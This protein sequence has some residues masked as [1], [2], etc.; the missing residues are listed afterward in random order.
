MRDMYTEDDLIF[1]RRIMPREDFWGYL[2][3][4]PLINTSA[5]GGHPRDISIH[6]RP[7]I[8]A[9]MARFPTLLTNVEDLVWEHTR[10]PIHCSFTSLDVGARLSEY[11]ESGVKHPDVTTL[12]QSSAAE[13]RF[14]ICPECVRG[15]IRDH[16]YA[17]W[18]V[19][20]L[21]P[22]MLVCPYHERTLLT[23]CRGCAYKLPWRIGHRCI[24]G[25]GL[26]PIQILDERAKE[27]ALGIARM[28]DALYNHARPGRLTPDDISDAIRQYF[29]A[30][31]SWDGRS[32]KALYD[33]LQDRLA[34]AT[35][36][37]LRL[38][39]HVADRYLPGKC[40]A[41][42]SEKPR[43]RCPQR[44]IAVAYALFGDWDAVLAAA[45]LAPQAAAGAVKKLPK[46]RSPAQMDAQSYREFVAKCGVDDVRRYT[47]AC[48]NWLRGQ[49]A[50]NP[51]LRRTD[52]IN[53]RQGHKVIKHLRLIDID[54]YDETLPSKSRMLMSDE[55]QRENTELES[56]VPQ[57]NA[58]TRAVVVSIYAKRDAILATSP[59]TRISRRCLGPDGAR[60]GA[61]SHHSRAVENA[62]RDCEES[63]DEWRRR[64]A[65]FIS[66]QVALIKPTH[67]YAN[68]SFFSI[69]DGEI[70]R[71][72]I[73]GA[74]KW[75]KRHGA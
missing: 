38:S 73:S 23:R 68:Y 31:D 66:E 26:E 52:L 65:R 3:N 34:Q 56:R 4:L 21:M 7:N 58:R 63:H 35:V 10:F 48:R 18:K 64:R 75:L 33:T 40:G 13:A 61:G 54:W 43:N 59:H 14:A 1:N 60:R 32:P 29:G 30:T 37:R 25:A 27:D 20:H 69:E 57:D 19:I 67:K 36:N 28:T 71:R 12:V 62:L 22:G 24:C 5:V 45:K 15:D 50:E 53:L 16:G 44:L 46:S 6:H 47:E 51:A 49:L 11:Y 8:L 70:Y 17:M 39:Y 9:A 74:R 2:A 55:N 72:R 42:T 41:T